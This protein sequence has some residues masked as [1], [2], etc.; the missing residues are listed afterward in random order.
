MRTIELQR[1]LHRRFHS[2]FDPASPL[3]ARALPTNFAQ[4]ADGARYQVSFDPALATIDLSFFFQKI[5][6]GATYKDTSLDV[7]W[8]GVQKLDLRGGYHYQR[9][10]VSWQAQVDNYLSGLKTHNIHALD[11]E[12]YGNTY[13]DTFFADGWRWINT[14]RE[15]TRQ[16]TL[17]YTNGS[18]YTLFA[19]AIL[20]LLGTGAGQKW[21]DELDLW[22]AWPSTTASEPPLQYKRENAI[23]PWTIWQDNWNCTQCGCKVAS[24]H[25]FF[26]GTEAELFEWA[27]V[28]S[29]PTPPPPGG[30][31]QANILKFI[32]IR[33]QP[34]N[35]T[36]DLGDL[37]AG[38]VIEYDRTQY[39]TTGQFTGD[40]YH[41][42][43]LTRGTNVTMPNTGEDWWCWGFNVEPIA[44]PPPSNTD[45]TDVRFSGEVIFDLA[46]GT[47]DVW[48][49]TDM[50][51]IKGPSI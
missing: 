15:Q 48:H 18:T 31:M 3:V 30:T 5:S 13:S 27:G 6:E 38:D 35:T 34:G 4:G 40:W 50:P 33:P 39:V 45:I 7:L 49:V 37:L 44:S 21:L 26:N 36:I 2:F 14:V 12:G 47:Q 32:N 51:F 42:T 11:M 1:H 29:T 19:A 16:K 20:R 28:T 41:I 8:Q 10:G 17:L 46:D 9:S 22:L 43:K 24:D 23:R 25:N